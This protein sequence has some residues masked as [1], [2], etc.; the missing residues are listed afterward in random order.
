MEKT[1]QRGS[2]QLHQKLLTV[3]VKWGWRK[4]S[5]DLGLP[6]YPLIAISFLHWKKNMVMP[7]FHW[8]VRVCSVT[9]VMSDS[10]WHYRLL[11]AR[12]L[13]PWDS[14]GRNTGVGCH[15]LLWGNLPDLEIEPISPCVSCTAGG[16]FA[17]WAIWEKYVKNSLWDLSSFCFLFCY[18]TSIPPSLPSQQC[19]KSLWGILCLLLYVALIGWKIQVLVFGSQKGQMLARTP[20]QGGRLHPSEAPEFIQCKRK[21]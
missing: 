13:C 11:P 2:S 9:S 10:L 15:S 5:L 17:N 12:L 3:H 1:F 19:P 18:K 4:G 8:V 21:C 7:V 20:T 16:F 14:P 6:S